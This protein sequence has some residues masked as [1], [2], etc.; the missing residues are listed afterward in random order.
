MLFD[1]NMLPFF[2]DQDHL[3]STLKILIK[4]RAKHKHKHTCRFP[5]QIVKYSK[6]SLKQGR[7]TNMNK[8]T[9]R[10]HVQIVK[11]AVTKE[12]H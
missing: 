3:A 7:N 4:T 5:V 10:F 2:K 11:Y 6:F 1:I 12:R 8:H 9:C